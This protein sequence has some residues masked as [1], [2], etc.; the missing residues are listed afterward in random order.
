MPHLVIANIAIGESIAGISRY[1]SERDIPLQIID[2][3]SG[4]GATLG[5]VTLGLSK[6]VEMGGR[7]DPTK[8]T[9][10]GIEGTVP[11]FDQLTDFS[12]ISLARLNEIGKLKSPLTAKMVTDIV[13]ETLQ[14]GEIT[15]ICGDIAKSIE[16]LTPTDSQ[17]EGLTVITANYS[18][19]RLPTMTKDKIIKDIMSK[20]KNV[21]FLISDLVENGSEVNRRYFNFRDNGLLN[22]G[23][24][25]LDGI[26][27][28]NN[29]SVFDL[30]QT[31]APRNMSPD[32]AAKIGDG[33]TS[34]SI[35]KVAYSGPLA[36]Q[37]VENW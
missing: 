19:H 6:G 32:L 31:N 21:I 23:N 25:G 17:K 33:V 2:L 15:L 22:C 10:A 9:I 14:P 4:S 16:A 24:Q 30:N 3:G 28:R 5:G 35:F 36:Q 29:L 26:F 7:I 37:I 8:L 34:D 13:N 11:M 1:T 20:N 12:E 18:W 27:M